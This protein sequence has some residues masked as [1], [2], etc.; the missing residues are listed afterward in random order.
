MPLLDRVFAVWRTRG[1]WGFA[2]FMSSRILQHRRDLVFDAETLA[3]KPTWDAPGA[4]LYI[5]R[6]NCERALTPALLRQLSRGEGAQYIDGLRG[7]DL[8]FVVADDAGR[9]LHHSFVLFETRTKALLGESPETPLFAHCVTIPEA[10]GQRLYPRTLHYGLSMLA[11]QGHPRAVINC[12]PTNRSSIAGIEH[13]G[14]KLLRELETW[15]VASRFGMQ[16]GRTCD[17][18][19]IA[20]VYCG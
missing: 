4:M 20:R 1:A 8:L 18:R 15:V 7:K 12:E 9:V 11:R 10:R 2:R 3:K 19:R 17:G 6:N 16:K 13:A 5:D 14:F